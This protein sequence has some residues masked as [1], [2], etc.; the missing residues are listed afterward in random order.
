MEAPKPVEAPKAGE[1][2]ADPLPVGNASLMPS[3]T[4]TVAP[5]YPPT[6]Q[7]LLSPWRLPSPWRPPRL[8]SEQ[9]T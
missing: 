1:S 7:R 6:L 4:L 8:V 9:R 5:L 3:G 2:H